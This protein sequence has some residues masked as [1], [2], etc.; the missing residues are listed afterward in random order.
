MKKL[1]QAVFGE[2][3]IWVNSMAVDSKGNI[4]CFDVNAER[5]ISDDNGWWG[6]GIGVSFQLKA[7]CDTTD[8]LSSA[9]DRA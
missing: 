9:I 3:P 4:C 7:G 1:T 8:W 5:L 2:V 6:E